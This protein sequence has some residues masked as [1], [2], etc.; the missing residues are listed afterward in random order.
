MSD[1]PETVSQESLREALIDSE[2]ARRLEKLLRI[3][4]EGLL[5][6]LQALTKTNSIKQVFKNLVDVLRGFVPFD[7]AVMLRENATGQL[8]T[9]HSTIPE[10]RTTHWDVKDTFTRV[11]NGEIVAA[12]DIS[13]IAEWNVLPEA[14]QPQVRS[15]IHTRLKTDNQ[16]AILIF[17]H[18][19]NAHFNQDHI[20]LLERFTPLG[21]QA[22]ANID[23]REHLER[24]RDA[25]KNATQAKSNFLANMSHELRT[26][27]NA[28]LGFSQMLRLDKDNTL[29]HVQN[30]YVS[31]ILLSGHHLLELINKMLDLAQI[32]A[33][34]ANLIMED[35]NAFDVVTEC[36]SLTAPLTKKQNITVINK[37]SQHLPIYIHTDNLRFKQCLINFLNNA[38]KYNVKGGSITIEGTILDDEFLRISVID[39]GIGIP[40]YDHEHVFQM[41]HRLDTNPAETKEGTGIGL[42]VTKVLIELLGGRIGL[43]SDEGIGST[44]WFD[45]PL[46]SNKLLCCDQYV[47]NELDI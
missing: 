26:P 24:E 11:M 47:E 3:E 4:T 30:D 28:I 38:I 45:L 41:F 9:I 15:A 8:I 37:F 13:L 29:S 12:F 19:N 42:N 35:V 6:G 36:I 25:A 27:M 21:N 18:S 31:N 7:N 43:E 33:N 5:N 44:F 16:Q 10:L 40:Q 46:T 14:L 34:Q 39:T 22:L 20:Q 32:E 2:N 23:I 17:T 1:H